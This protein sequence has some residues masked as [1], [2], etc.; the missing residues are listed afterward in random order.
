MGDCDDPAD[1]D[2][3]GEFDAIDMMILEDGEQEKKSSGGGGSG[4]CIV[5]LVFGASCGSGYWVVSNLL[6]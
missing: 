4:C 1:L 6:T 5:L 2:G 3:D